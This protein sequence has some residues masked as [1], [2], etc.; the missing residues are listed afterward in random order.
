MRSDLTCVVQTHSIRRPLAS[1]ARD[2]RLSTPASDQ[3]MVTTGGAVQRK[4]IGVWATKA[5]SNQ[6]VSEHKKAYTQSIDSR[7][8]TRPVILTRRTPPR[9][10]SGTDSSNLDSGGSLPWQASLPVTSNV[11]Y[12]NVSAQLRGPAGNITSTTTVDVNGTQVTKTGTATG[13]YNIASA[14]ICGDFWVDWQPG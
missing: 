3:P 11:Q 10:K 4:D 14:Q 12:F 8:R 2:L 9:R 5:E 6:A 7:G 13:N 1:L